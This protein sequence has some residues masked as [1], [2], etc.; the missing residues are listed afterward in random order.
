MSYRSFIRAN[1]YRPFRPSLLQRIRFRRERKRSHPR[2]P[3]L[4]AKMFR[5]LLAWFDIDI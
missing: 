1:G 4:L 3:G 5:P 2:Q